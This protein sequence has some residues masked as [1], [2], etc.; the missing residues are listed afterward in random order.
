MVKRADEGLRYM[1]RENSPYLV[2]PVYE[3]YSDMCTCIA[4]NS[5]MYMYYYR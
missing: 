2:A 3:L 5:D 4:M 1:L